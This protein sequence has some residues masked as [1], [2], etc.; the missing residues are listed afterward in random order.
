MKVSK[1]KAQSAIPARKVRYRPINP[2]HLPLLSS[3]STTRMQ[4][5]ITE[6]ENVQAGLKRLQAQLNE[7]PHNPRTSILKNGTVV[8][9]EVTKCSSSLTLDKLIVSDYM[10]KKKINPKELTPQSKKMING[11]MQLLH[12]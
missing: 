9:L 10:S 3:D 4:N 2:A 6:K 11:K 12:L 8:V 5:P 7:N 1:R